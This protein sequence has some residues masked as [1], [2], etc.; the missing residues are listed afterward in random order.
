MAQVRTKDCKTLLAYKKRLALE[1][2]KHKIVCNVES[3][4]T[5]RR[6]KSPSVYKNDILKELNEMSE[7][8]RYP[9]FFEQKYREAIK[10]GL[11]NINEKTG[12]VCFKHTK[13]KVKKSKDSTVNVY[14]TQE[15]F[16]QLREYSKFGDV[17]CLDEQGSRTPTT[18]QPIEK[19]RIKKMPPVKIKNQYNVPVMYSFRVPVSIH[20]TDHKKNIY[21]YYEL[22]DDGFYYNTNTRLDKSPKSIDQLLRML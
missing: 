8:K 7:G 12:K 22:K 21:A 10:S 20:N 19:V 4:K 15:Q 14:V 5:K 17:F 18:E 6:S 2:L 1:K 3:E 16:S 13:P 11:G 9:R